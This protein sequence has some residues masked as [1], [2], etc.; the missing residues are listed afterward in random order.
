MVKSSDPAKTVAVIGA[1]IA[2]LSTGCYA[3][4]NGYQTRIF[5]MHSKPGGLCTSWERSGYTIDCCIHWLTGSKPGSSLYKLWQEVG[6]IQGLDLVDSDEMMR[7]EFPDGPTVVIYTDVDRLQEHLLQIA[8]EDASLITKFLADARRLAELDMPSDMPPRE[9]MGLGDMLRVVP[10]MFRV[11]R[12]F[13]RWKDMTI[14][15][16]VEGIKNPYVREALR[17]VWIPEMSAFFLVMTLAWFHGR[18]AGYP[19]GGSLPLARAVE[20]RFLDLGGTIDYR[21]RVSEILVEND[22]AVGVRLADGREE[23]SDVVISAAD[24][25]ATIFDMLMGRYVDDTVRGWFSDLTPFPP[26]VFIGLGVD[27][28]FTHEPRAVSGISLALAEPLQ[29]GNQSV[30]RL[31]CR[32]HNFDPTMAPAGKTAVTC[33]FGADYDYWRRLAEDREAYEAEK[34]AIAAGVVKALDRR[35]PGLADKVEVV[36][37][38]TPTTFERYTGNWRASFE[39]WLP[40]PKAAML[41]MSKTLPGLRSFYMAGQWVAPG[42]GIPTGVMT[43]RQVVQLMCH[44]DGRRFETSLP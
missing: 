1:G 10:P 21:A 38:A 23:R 9:L 39:G 16:F 41:E 17:E 37:V 40:T 22:R 14:T 32:L 25:H 34:R 13:R 33:M 18:Q 36:D 31:A 20:K 5:E 11:M 8:P 4:M 28:D 7:I 44:E 27:R 26:L 43:A 29:I 35:Y 3:Q 30:D 24:A 12:P 19:I 2:G 15:Q 6:L 42:G